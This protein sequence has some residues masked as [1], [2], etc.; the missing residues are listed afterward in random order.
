MRKYNTKVMQFDIEPKV[1]IDIT[2]D[3]IIDFYVWLWFL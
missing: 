2:I 1:K 3:K